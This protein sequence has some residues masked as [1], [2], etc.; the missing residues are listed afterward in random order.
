MAG[1]VT[2]QGVV[3]SDAYSGSPDF[4]YILANDGAGASGSLNGTTAIWLGRSSS[5]ITLPAGLTAFGTDYAV[6]I[7]GPGGLPVGQTSTIEAT[8]HFRDATAPEMFALSVTGKSQFF[9][10]IGPEIDYIDL[11]YANNHYMVFDNMSIAQ[12][13]PEPETY[14]LM[15]TGLGLVGFVARQGRRQN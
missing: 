8:F 12:A 5:R 4:V 1:S 7:G 15:L 10:Y 2:L 6:P 3:F 9:G 14:A 13:V 11:A